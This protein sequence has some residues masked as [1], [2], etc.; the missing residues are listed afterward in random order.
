[1]KNHIQARIRLA[2]A[3]GIS[4]VSGV[5]QH[6]PHAGWFDPF[7]SAD[8]DYKVL[9]WV[10]VQRGRSRWIHFKNALA[11]SGSVFACNYKVGDFARAA[12]QALLK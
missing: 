8:D 10:R 4:G 7:T 1:M 9:E 3:I 2:E 5:K 11:E 12:L 6:G